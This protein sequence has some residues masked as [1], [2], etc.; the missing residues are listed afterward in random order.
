MSV[1]TI[2]GHGVMAQ[3]TPVMVRNVDKHLYGFGYRMI[4]LRRESSM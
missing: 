4:E 2:R 1:K 3:F